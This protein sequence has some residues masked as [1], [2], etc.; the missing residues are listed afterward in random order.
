MGLNH[1]ELNIGVI[2]SFECPPL[3]FYLI[4]FSASFPVTN[5]QTKW[6]R[7]IFSRFILVSSIASNLIRTGPVWVQDF[8]PVKVSDS[9]RLISFIWAFMILYS[10][11]SDWLE[12]KT[13]RIRSD[14]PGLFILILCDVEGRCCWNYESD[15]ASW[16]RKYYNDRFAE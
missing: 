4:C 15:P 3:S 9:T 12:W 5:L 11:A 2:P 14:S 10:L 1:M 13:Y 6:P 16:W 7:L 8:L